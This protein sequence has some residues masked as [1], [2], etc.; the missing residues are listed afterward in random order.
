[1]IV[2]LY[3]RFVQLVEAYGPFEYV[4]GKDG[5]AFKGQRRNFDVA[6]PK[7]KVTITF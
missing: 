4:V 2:S 6:K 7:A 1:M 5:I 3:E